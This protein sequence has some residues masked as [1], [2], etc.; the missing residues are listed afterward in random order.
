M[1][2]IFLT[3]SI[4][5]IPLQKL[6]ILALISLISCSV[7]NKTKPNLGNAKPSS[8]QLIFKCF[9]ALAQ[10]TNSRTQTL[11]RIIPCLS[12]SAISHQPSAIS[13]RSIRG[14]SPTVPVNQTH[15]P[16]TSYL[17]LEVAYPFLRSVPVYPYSLWTPF[18]SKGGF[19]TQFLNLWTFVFYMSCIPSHSIFFWISNT[20]L[21]ATKPGKI[22]PAISL[23]MFSIH[24]YTFFFIKLRILVRCH[25]HID[26]TLPWFFGW[27]VVLMAR[28]N[29]G[30]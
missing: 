17:F 9:D 6:I 13:L 8:A 15:W 26:H 22:L 12:P 27:M 16:S 23:R 24:K 7:C 25:W 10:K 28:F 5:D 20:T 1:L 18:I 29:S 19:Y 30:W 3:Y 14:N 4:I 21:C 2:M 11:E